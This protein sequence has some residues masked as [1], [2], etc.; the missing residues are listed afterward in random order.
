MSLYRMVS[1]LLDFS[2]FAMLVTWEI[3]SQGEGLGKKTKKRLLIDCS[4]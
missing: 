4:F 3:R 2:L 1:M